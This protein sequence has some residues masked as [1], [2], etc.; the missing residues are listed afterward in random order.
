VQRL[1]EHIEALKPDQREALKLWYFEGMKPAEIAE[2][3]DRSA[4][5]C[6][7][8]VGRALKTL[9]RKFKESGVTN[10]A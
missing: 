2:R 10:G 6:R 8:M 5:A 9:G 7:M 4:D 3:M 1:E